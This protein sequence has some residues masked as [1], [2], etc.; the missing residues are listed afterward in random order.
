MGEGYH[1]RNSALISL[2]SA[3]GGL[4]T[5]YR[6][7]TIFLEQGP[8]A[9]QKFFGEESNRLCAT[10]EYIM[11]DVVKLRLWIVTLPCASNVFHRVLDKRSVI[12]W[13]IEV[14]CSK[15]IDHGIYFEYCSF[16]T[17]GNQSSWCC[18]YTKTTDRCQL[19]TSHWN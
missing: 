4:I 12:R 16:D 7:D 15:L 9:R 18:P 14:T 6:N 2:V 1:L 5:Y 13:K 17:V 10:C 3:I 19:L 8:Q 11:D